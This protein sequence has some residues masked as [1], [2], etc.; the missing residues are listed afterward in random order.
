M[1]WKWRQFGEADLEVQ[2]ER[3]EGYNRHRVGELRELQRGNDGNALRICI[4]GLHLLHREHVDGLRGCWLVKLGQR[5]R[6]NLE[7]EPHWVE[8]LL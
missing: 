2:D 3:L 5:T 4:R 1:C 7:K 8:R 6:L